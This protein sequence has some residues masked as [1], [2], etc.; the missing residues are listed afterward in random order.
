MNNSM[1][2]KI[3]V[4]AVLVAAYA[5]GFTLLMRD[6]NDAY[7]VQDPG[8]AV[9]GQMDS[10]VVPSPALAST[11]TGLSTS[12]P[13]DPAA[14]AEEAPVPAASAPE[15]PAPQ[16][17]ATVKSPVTPAP[18]AK[19]VEP[20]PKPQPRQTE[21]AVQG[22]DIAQPGPASELAS[23]ASEPSSVDL[24][25]EAAPPAPVASPSAG[26]DS[27]ITAD[28]KAEIAVVAPTGS[29]EVTTTDGVVE[30]TG[31]VHSQEEVEKVRMAA[32]NVPAV[33]EVDVSALMVSN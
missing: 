24:A 4:G 25:A 9:T 26:F 27:Q 17:P 30:L 14:F 23:V 28:V 32:S 20:Q 29:I 13:A 11:A 15:L 18:Q 10:G 6:K 31:S 3:V 33:R 2:P 21:Q 22:T 1:T 19:V 5:T 8:V 16:A 7:V 12:V